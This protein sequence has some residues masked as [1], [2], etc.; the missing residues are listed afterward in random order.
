MEIPVN[1]LDSILSYYT[2][3]DIME[4]YGLKTDCKF[5]NP[6]RQ[7]NNPSCSCSLY[8]NKFIFKDWTDGKSF[9][10]IGVAGLYYG[11]L[12]Y[13]NNDYYNISSYLYDAIITLMYE[14]LVEGKSLPK[15]NTNYSNWDNKEKK[16]TT[17]EV[18]IR[19]WAKYD[20]EYFSPLDTS[21]FTNIYPLRW[22]MING[23][24]CL[25]STPSNPT[26]GYYFSNYSNDNQIWKI[27]KPLDLKGNKWLS[28]VK[29]DMVSS[30]GNNPKILCTSLK[31]AYSIKHILG[32]NAYSFQSESYM[33]LKILEDT[34]YVV[35]DNDKKGLEYGEYC[36][37][38]FDV[39]II[40]PIKKDV[41]LDLKSGYF[42]HYKNIIKNGN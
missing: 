36:K 16:E 33:P 5:N 24:Q 42:E 40:T 22:A 8:N 39:E 2:E 21:S 12:D 9:T 41:F 3:K 38:N 1:K 17:I 35:I 27:Y 14:D 34:K 30:T 7:D 31:D 32:I 18:S 37:N 4:F 13:D 23:V 26:Y 10:I 25:H 28:N 11:L 20:L 29:K 6:F 19:D 15:L